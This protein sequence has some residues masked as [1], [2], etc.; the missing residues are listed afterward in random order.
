[1]RT[2]LIWYS[3]LGGACIT[4]LAIVLRM[5]G[6]PRPAFY[7]SYPGIYLM[8]SFLQSFLDWLPWGLGN[9]IT[10]ALAFILANTV[11]FAL[12]IFLLLRI[13]VPDRSEELPPI[14]G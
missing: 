10:E 4:A 12:V 5:H 6:V 2:K 8:Q 1:M 13:F 3:L 14:R 11:S 7:L 9:L